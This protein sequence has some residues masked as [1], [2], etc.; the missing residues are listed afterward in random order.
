M[1]VG[2]CSNKEVSDDHSLESPD[3]MDS[4]KEVSG[5]RKQGRRAPS[6]H[7]RCYRSGISVSRKRTRDQCWEVHSRS[8]APD[9]VT[10]LLGTYFKGI[11]QRAKDDLCKHLELLTYISKQ[12]KITSK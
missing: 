10:E 4:E 2:G 8:I 7:A 12:L 1:C 6:P 11:T 9:P 5:G 3:L